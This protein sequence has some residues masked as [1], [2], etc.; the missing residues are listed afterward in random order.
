M[1]IK[2]ELDRQRLGYIAFRYDSGT[3]MFQGYDGSTWKYLD[4][5]RYNAGTSLFEGWNG[6]V[7]GSIGGGLTITPIDPTFA[8]TLAVGKHYLLDMTAA[9]GDVTLSLPAG[10][11]GAN[12]KIMVFANTATSYRLILQANGSDTVYYNGTTNATLRV[13]PANFWVELGWAPSPRSYWVAENAG[14]LT[15]EITSRQDADSTLQSNINAEITARSNADSTLTSNLNSEITARANADSTLKSNLNSEI[16]ARSNADSTLTSN[17][18][19]EITARS[20]ADST[21]Q[22]NINAE[23]TARMAADSVIISKALTGLDA[24]IESTFT[25]YT[26]S[27]FAF[28]KNTFFGSTTG[29]DNILASG[30]VVLNATQQFISSSLQGSTMVADAPIVNAAQA[31]LLYNT[32][33]IDATPTVSI[34]RDGGNSW[35]AAWQQAV[36][37]NNI[38]SDVIFPSSSTPSFDAGTPNGTQTAAYYIAEIFQPTY[39]TTFI[40]FGAYVKLASSSSAGTVVGKLMAVSGGVPTTVIATSSTTLLVGQ[41]ITTT[42]SYKVFSFTSVPLNPTTQY[43]VVL[44]STSMSVNLSVD[45]V[46][47]APAYILGSATSANGSSWSGSGSTDLA[48]QIYGTG[49][50][51]KLKV[52]SGTASSELA[53]FGVEMVLDTPT[54]YAGDATF[55]TRVITSTEASTGLITLTQARFTP[56]AHQLHCNYKG[57]DFVAPDFIELGGGA[58]QF[59]LNFFATG[60]TAKF[61]VGYGLVNLSNAPWTVNY[62][63]ADLVKINH[64]TELTT[65]HGVIIANPIS[66]PSIG[67]GT[68][69]PSVALDVV[70]NQNISGAINGNINSRMNV[71]ISSIPTNPLVWETGPAG[72]GGGGAFAGGVLLPNGKVFAIPYS[73]TGT[74]TI[75]NPTTNA[76]ETGPAG[77]GGGA[78]QGGVLLPNGKVFAIPYSY[79]G[80]NTIYNPTTNAWETGPAGSGSNA[81]VSGVLLPNGKVFAI[82]YSYTGTNTIYNPTTNAWEVGP[83]GPGGSAF[84]GG[85]LLPNGKVFAIPYSYTSTNTIYNPTTNAWEVGPAGPGSNAFAGG[86]LLPN[87]KVFAIPYSY[88]GTNTI[89]NPAVVGWPY[90]QWML[91]S[92]FNKF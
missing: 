70:G 66:A 54:T 92:M 18:N 71:L 76:W 55:E 74:N 59:P 51:V 33:A 22:S 15:A 28:D 63:E 41:D 87:G 81:F 7:W 39:L 4:K 56:G 16:T 80:T 46:S 23:I 34:S 72:S 49:L 11:S 50:D 12:I 91:H 17:L 21:L 67:I 35:V 52:V 82:P 36:S 32:G 14:D 78:F 83:A 79:T 57:H 43:A 30:K 2:S 40:A 73:Y 44:Y 62:M 47:A 61:Y 65:G 8:S 75:Y 1:T 19:S 42:S 24:N 88:T 20:N 10:A 13:S 48:F 6:S 68:P 27:D 86:V 90:G 89:Y 26:R 64:I 9:T 31:K 84:A 58:V 69:T 37:G 60:D 5:L 53:G 3:G 38:I 45:Q 29:T 77:P 25:Y 85:V